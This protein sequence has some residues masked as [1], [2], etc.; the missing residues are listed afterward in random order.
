LSELVAFRIAAQN[1]GYRETAFVEVM[2]DEDADPTCQ[3][4]DQLAGGG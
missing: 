2:Q 4:F 3:V 1:A